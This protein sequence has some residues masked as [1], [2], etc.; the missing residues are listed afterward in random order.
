LYFE[1][2][3]TATLKI[4]FT[5]NPKPKITWMHDGEEVRGRNY[6]QEV[7]ERHATLT[8]KDA[9]KDQDGPYRITAENNLGSDSAVIK[10]QIN[11][12]GD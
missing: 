9:N 11:G 10:I 4:P 5:G 8:I 6:I 7:T 3:E 12:K 2:G 1:K